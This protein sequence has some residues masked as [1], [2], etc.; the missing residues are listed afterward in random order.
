MG[1]EMAGVLKLNSGELIERSTVELS[2]NEL[3]EEWHLKKISLI[4][5]I[6]RIAEAKYR[7]DDL[8]FT[9]CMQIAEEIIQTFKRK[10]D[11]YEMKDDLAHLNQSIH[12]TDNINFHMMDACE[13]L[14]NLY[15]DNE[16]KAICK[17]LP[18]PID[19]YNVAID[20]YTIILDKIQLAH[21]LKRRSNCY[22]VKMKFVE[23]ARDLTAASNLEADDYASICNEE[24]YEK[25]KNYY[26]EM[27][28]KF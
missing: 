19:P 23:A 14:A 28:I 13:E 4:Q 2:I 21:I 12:L 20:L 27:D 7:F 26:M 5:L 16:N 9:L 25:I 22:N 8:E 24:Y 18:K 3:Y 17:Q 1:S 15:Q 11:G 6:N 10:E